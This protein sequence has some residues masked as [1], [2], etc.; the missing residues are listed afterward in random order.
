MRMRRTATSRARVYE[1]RSAGVRLGGRGPWV[2]PGP[3]APALSTHRTLRYKRRF[4]LPHKHDI[5][6][7]SRTIKEIM[8]FQRVQLLLVPAPI[9]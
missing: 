2:E 5:D 1:S 7:L 6:A 8:T 9:T 4:E 3:I